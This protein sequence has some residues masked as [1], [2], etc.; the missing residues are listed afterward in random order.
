[1]NFKFPIRIRAPSICVSF[2]CHRNKIK[3]LDKRTLDRIDDKFGSGS[4]DD[5][6]KKLNLN[7]NP[8]EC[9]CYLRPFVK[10]VKNTRTRLYDEVITK[11]GGVTM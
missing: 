7:W 2:F 6:P 4:G 8:W 3:R 10:W 11:T 1:M 9:D 5:G